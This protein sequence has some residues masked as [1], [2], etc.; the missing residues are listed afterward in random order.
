MI[1]NLE[2]EMK[3]AAQRLDFEEAIQLRDRIATLKKEL[4]EKGE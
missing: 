3:T 2:T 1:I 4:E